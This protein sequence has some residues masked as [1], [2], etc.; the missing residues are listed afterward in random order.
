MREI[1]LLKI[2]FKEMKKENLIAFKYCDNKGNIID[3]NNPNG[4]LDNIAGILNEKKIF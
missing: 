3:E 2:S 1:I 4:S